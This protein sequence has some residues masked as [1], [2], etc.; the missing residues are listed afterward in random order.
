M[1]ESK[2]SYFIFPADLSSH[3]NEAVWNDNQ[4]FSAF[5]LRLPLGQ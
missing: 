5:Y 4:V 1:Q 2:L 3:L